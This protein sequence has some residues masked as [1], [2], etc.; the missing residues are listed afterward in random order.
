[1]LKEDIFKS[2]VM[3]NG[4]RGPVR[5]WLVH[6]AT[7]VYLQPAMFSMGLSEG[8]NPTRPKS[9]SPPSDLSCFSVIFALL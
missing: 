2:L 3:G 6:Q 5:A 9:N 7:Q 4:V 1:M 8:F